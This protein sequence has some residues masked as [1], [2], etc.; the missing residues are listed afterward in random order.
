MLDLHEVSI[1]DLHEHIVI[2]WPWT[3]FDFPS[4]ESLDLSSSNLTLN[5]NRT[6]D[7]NPKRVTYVY[8]IT[9]LRFLQ[10]RSTP[11]ATPPGGHL[12]HS[13]TITRSPHSRL[14]ERA[15]GGFHCCVPS[16]ETPGAP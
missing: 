6:S 3:Y 16:C 5:K 14:P 12:F 8:Y 13:E 4:S 9:H 15:R 2:D 1:D 10:V 11:G 7:P